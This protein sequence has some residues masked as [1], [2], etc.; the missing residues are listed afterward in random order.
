MFKS[1]PCIFISMKM[2]GIYINQEPETRN[3]KLVHFFPR[4][5]NTPAF[6]R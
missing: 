4:H 5:N 1:L 3:W 2:Q 6:I